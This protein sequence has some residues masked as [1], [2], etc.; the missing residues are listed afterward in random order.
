MVENYANLE[1][2]QVERWSRRNK[3]RFNETKTK[4]MLVTR[5]KRREDKTIILYLHSRPIDNLLV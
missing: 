1:L 4:V 3:F 5:K 2:S